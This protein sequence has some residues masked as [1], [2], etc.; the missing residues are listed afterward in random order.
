MRASF[1]RGSF[2]VRQ[3]KPAKRRGSSLAHASPMEDEVRSDAHCDELLSNTRD[4]L[5]ANGQSRLSRRDR[6][7][8]RKCAGSESTWSELSRES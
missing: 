3:R 1:S 2:R 4:I 8:P 7:G 6:S 5:L